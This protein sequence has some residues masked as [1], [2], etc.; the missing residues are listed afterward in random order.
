[1]VS[2]QYRLNRLFAPDGKCFDVAIDHGFF[3]EATFLS[4]IEDPARAIAA[5]V[6]ASPDAIQLPPG[7]ARI[8]QSIPG[9][10]KP[11]LVLRT[12]TANVYGS[13][14]PAS[15]HSELIQNAVEQALRLDA[16][17]I[18]V[19]LLSLPGQS[20]LLNQCVRNVS[21]LKSECDR[22]GMPLMVEPLVM[23][24]NGIAGGY[25]V[26]GEIRK[27]LP[28]VRMAVELGADIIKCDPCSEISEF[29]RIVEIAG[30]FPVLVRGGG[31]ATD[32]EIL[33]RTA[34]LMAQGASGIVYGRNVIQHP[35][36]TLMTQ[37]LMSIVHN[38]KSGAEAL[39]LLV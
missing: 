16:A 25:Q 15:L 22:F 33:V 1:V 38:G 8:L 9:P 3:N 18:V 12:D 39:E 26:D 35:T 20:E 31:R 36:P 21:S 2:L 37:A 30:G 5:V 10:R 32:E 23:Q 4:G 34:A 27:I 28:L 11:A 6:A 24:A 17:C 29:H 19:N 7:S 13:V 14:L